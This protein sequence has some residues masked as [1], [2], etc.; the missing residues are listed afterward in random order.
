MQK[1]KKLKS[2]S[3]HI[4]RVSHSRMELSG[5]ERNAGDRAWPSET[6][7]LGHGDVTI[8]VGGGPNGWKE[9]TNTSWGCADTSTC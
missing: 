8:Y 6:Q 2:F 9:I 7:I 1:Q 3:I 5:K 4:V